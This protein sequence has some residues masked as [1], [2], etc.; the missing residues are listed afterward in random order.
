MLICHLH[1]KQYAFFLLVLVILQIVVAVFAFMYTADLANAAKD[2][3][4]RLFDDRTTPATG[5][6][7]DQIQI[8]LQC[9]GT[10]GPSSWGLNP[11]ASCCAQ[12]PCTLANS[13]PDGCS[14]KL[15]DI[16]NG[17][18]LL[19]AWV[20]IIF[21]GIQLVGVIFAC[22]RKYW[23]PNLNYGHYL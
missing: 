18:G 15:A 2:G 8:G 6:A 12:A 19:I 3:F 14:T 4:A 20:A 21:A 11:P 23:E 16:V 1:P 17:S 10:T 13:H 9:C 7:I 5:A 22:C